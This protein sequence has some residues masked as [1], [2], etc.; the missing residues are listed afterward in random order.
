MFLCNS[1]KDIY[2]AGLNN[3]LGYAKIYYD[4]G[5]GFN[6]HDSVII[7]MVREEDKYSFKLNYSF[8][9]KAI[10]I[11]PIECHFI[12]VRNYSLEI[13]GKLQ[14]IIIPNLGKAEADGYRIIET[15][16]PQLIAEMI[17]EKVMELLFE[18]EMKLVE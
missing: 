18:A 12:K 17:D 9:V 13:N 1:S 10:R 5:S 3:G 7:K 2:E 6:E 4:Y 15:N 8:D 14:K 11:D 16:D